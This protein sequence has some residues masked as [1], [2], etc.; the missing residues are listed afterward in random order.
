MVASV[1]TGRLKQEIDRPLAV[2]AKGVQ[3]GVDDQARRTPGHRVEHPEALRLGP[4]EPISSASFSLYTPTLDVRPPTI[5]EP[6]RRN[7]LS[8]VFS[9]SRAIWK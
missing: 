4:E 7:V 8:S 6:R 5:R 2:P 1:L 9:I 3:A